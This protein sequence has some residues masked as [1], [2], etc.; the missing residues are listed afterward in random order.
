MFSFSR[1]GGVLTAFLALSFTTTS[2]SLAAHHHAQEHPGMRHVTV[3]GRATLEVDPDHALVRLG[4]AESRATTTEARD[5]VAKVVEQFLAL[6]DSLGVER[7]DISTSNVRI[8]PEY[9]RQRSA[10][11]QGPQIVGYRVSRDLSVT[12]RDL[13]HLGPLVERSIALGANQASPPTFRVTDEARVQREA[14]RLAAEEARR[15]A[16]VLADT[17]DAKVGAVRE[18]AADDGATRPPVQPYARAALA[19]SAASG[20]DTYDPGQITIH[21]DVRVTFDL[22]VTGDGD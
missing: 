13:G 12:L 22:V 18:I 10:G 9:A 16:T 7:Q 8:Q 6:C 19:S 21:A 1:L 17:L 2:T 14:L 5:A 15:R 20:E 3:S 11:S 4:V